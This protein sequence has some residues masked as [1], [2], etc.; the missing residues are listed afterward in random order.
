MQIR[1]LG[2]PGA[3]EMT[4]QIHGDM[5]GGFFEW[6]R[7]D[8]FAETTGHDLRLAQA[9]S[10]VSAAGTVR[11]VH[12]AE[13]PPS[14]A[15]Y[16]TCPAGALFDVVVDIRV[17]SR[18]YG[19]WEGV[20]LDDV[21]RKAVYVGEGLGHAFMALEDATVA[22]YLCSAP[23]SPDREHAIDPLDP[24]IGIVWPREGRGGS[25][26]E[27]ILSEKDAAA[28]GLDDVRRAGLL[29]G[30]D[31]VLAYLETLNHKGP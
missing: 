7:A 31:A 25:P 26:L 14:Q 22:C 19:A 16:V 24:E 30:Y 29:P 12:F 5:R 15:K 17:G 2:I 8:R 18:T 10:S 3:F 13:L 27:P 28:P 20:L 9:N 4:P 21:N 23:Y 6:F 11:G 1:E